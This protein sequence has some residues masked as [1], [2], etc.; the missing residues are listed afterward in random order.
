MAMPA[1]LIEHADRTERCLRAVDRLADRGDIGDVHLHRDGASALAP[2]FLLE[3][4][5]FGGLPRR[6]HDRGAMRRKHPRELPPQPLEAPVTRM[7]SLLTS[8]KPDMSSS[9]EN[10]TRSLIQTILAIANPFH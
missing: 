2:N 8:N 9:S 5:Q 10:S 3:A 1:L 6:Q 7:I 4:F